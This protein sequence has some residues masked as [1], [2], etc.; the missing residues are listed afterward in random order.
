M[1]AKV[2]APSAT[3]TNC[4]LTNGA[5]TEQIQTGFTCLMAARARNEAA[6]FTIIQCVDCWIA[7]TFVT[8]PSRGL[9]RIF[10][11]YDTFGD[12]KRVSSVDTCSDASYSEEADISCA[13]PRQI[14]V[15]EGALSDVR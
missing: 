3:R 2:G 4:G 14:F 12:S 11:E 1:L 5:L 6:E 15:C 8:L 9:F 7:D 10:T 13:E